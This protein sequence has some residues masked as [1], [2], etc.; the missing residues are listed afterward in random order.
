MQN[1]KTLILY[2]YKKAQHF[3]KDYARLNGK[4]LRFEKNSNNHKTIRITLNNDDC[5]DVRG[6]IYKQGTI[7]WDAYKTQ[8]WAKFKILDGDICA[9]DYDD[10]KLL[11]FPAWAKI[12]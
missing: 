9:F 11:E 4:F 12:A 2:S 10:N 6:S 8:S 5:L 1:K 7:S 3:K